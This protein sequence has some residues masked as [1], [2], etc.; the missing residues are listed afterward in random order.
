MTRWCRRYAL[1]VIL[2][3]V[4]A[5]TLQ[6]CVYDPAGPQPAYGGHFYVAPP[7]ERGG[8]GGGSEGGGGMK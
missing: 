1:M 3:I 6:G 5:G 8:G 4:G 7:N 2:L